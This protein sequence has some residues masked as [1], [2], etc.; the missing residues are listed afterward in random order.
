MTKNRIVALLLAGLMA[1]SMASCRVQ[2]NNPGGTEPNQNQTTPPQG[3]TAPQNPDTPPV[4]TWQD[5]DK[6]VY[7][8]QSIKLRKDAAAN[9]TAL[10]EIPKETALH[11]TQQNNSWYY[12]EYDGAQ[13]YISKASVTEIN[14][15]ATD[16][17]EVEGGSKIMYSNSNNTNIR[18]YPATADF[19]SVMGG[20][21][22]ND[23]VT[24]VATNGTWFKIQYVKNNIENFY[25]VHGSCLEDERVTDPNDDTPYQALF[26]SVAGTPTMYVSGVDS[27]YFRKAP[28]TSSDGI[29]TL[30][31]GDSV[32][33]LKTG[34]VDGKNWTY[35]EVA[36]P[37]KK[38]GDGY[39]YEKGYVSSDCLAYTNGEMTLEN[40]L[41][42][43]TNFTQTDVT[44]YVL[45]EKTITIRS[46]PVFPEEGQDNSLSHP[47]SGIAPETIK[48][49]KVLATG[50]VDG[51]QWFIV[52]FTKKDGE[53][54]KVVRGF[55]GGKA[56][57]YLTSDPSGK[58]TVT[59][60]DLLLKYPDEFEVLE[61]PATV[62]T[63][64]IAN[65]YGA[66]V[67]ANEPLKQLAQG[68]SVTLVAVE[69]TDG[70]ATWA[71]IQDGEGAYYF[72]QISLLNV[73]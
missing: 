67:V 21:K 53:N 30:K 4:T 40:L 68:A 19:S 56:L 14:I 26:S 28:N 24:V 47:Q 29:L 37:P 71:V 7:T 43:Y 1:A 3:T 12:V 15:L 16:F 23:E 65:C 44:M 49:I 10:K 39:T 52:E 36:V 18:L 55:V 51:V 64:N 72:I 17:V 20:Y 57:D 35:A 59:L 5:V 45:Q 73:A 41:A 60:D 66:P 69:K 48:M 33:V 25:Y 8:T 13:G 63:K 70:N 34:T 54:D 22:L 32:T 6:T 62:T 27:V 42:I 58:P 61:T 9:S 31:K 11:C 38:E 46:A 2:N 50:E